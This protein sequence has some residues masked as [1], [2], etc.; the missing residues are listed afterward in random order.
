MNKKIENELLREFINWDISINIKK[1]NPGTPLLF[2]M[3]IQNN[4]NDIWNIIDKSEAGEPH[5]KI[6][7]F[8]SKYLN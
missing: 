1:R 3:Y 5:Q 4:R 7:G 2:S 6:S 8:I